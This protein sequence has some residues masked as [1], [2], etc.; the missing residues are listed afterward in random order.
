MV[1]EPPAAKSGVV[2]HPQRWRTGAT[3][4]AITSG[5]PVPATACTMSRAEL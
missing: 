4:A 1:S 3:A 2:A 5:I